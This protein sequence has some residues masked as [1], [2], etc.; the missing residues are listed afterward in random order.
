M[1]WAYW[2]SEEKWTAWRLL[3]SVVGLN[4]ALVYI[5]VQMNHWQGSFYYVIQN[6]DQSGFF[7]SIGR[8]V[9]L[10]VLLILIKGYQLYARML[11]H[12]HWRRWLTNRYLSLWLRTNTYYRLQLQG[13]VEA[14][15]PDQRISEDVEMFVSLSLRLSI[16]ALQDVA[17]V[18]SFV[19]ILWNL[20]GVFYLPV[21]GTHVAIHGYLVW[22]ALLYAGVGTYWTL[23]LG[24]PLVSLD[25]NLQ[26]FEADF[27]FALMRVREHA[28]SIAFYG[29]ERREKHRCLQQFQHIWLVFGQIIQVRKRLTWLTTA[30][31]HIAVIFAIIVA[32]PRY[33]S[34]QIHLGHMFQVID[35]YHHVQSGFS[36]IIDNFSRL[37]QWRAVVNRLNGFLLSVDTINSDHRQR[38]ELISTMQPAQCCLREVTVFR[39]DGRFLVEKLSFRLSVGERLLITGASGCGKSTLLRTLAGLWPFAAGK[40]MIPPAGEAMFIPQKSYIPQDSL[41]NVLVYPGDP[42]CVSDERL[43]QLLALC[44]LPEL[45]NRLD[46]RGDWGQM[47]SL[48]EQQRVA[49]VR[50]LVRRPQW[51]FLDEVTSAMDETTEQAVYQVLRQSLPSATVVSVGHRPALIQY[52]NRR[53][54]LDGQGGWTVTANREAAGN[55]LRWPGRL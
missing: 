2:F 17:T 21:A 35:A 25:Y 38:A 20:S 6:Y 9:V 54:E 41:R 19:I 24:R 14:D 8:Y 12:I 31:S 4:L 42:S 15:N 48:G 49:F 11:L 55:P 23:R 52:H 29:G 33:F 5:I 39:P 36:F 30:Y 16:D 22:A 37:A 18:L 10:A 28:E 46:D 32:S 45:A 51:L 3:L 40:V 7:H 50:M 13:G 47:L 1:A 44:R 43:K 34:G 26:R 53:L 27:R